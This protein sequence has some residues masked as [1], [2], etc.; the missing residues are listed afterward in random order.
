MSARPVKFTLIELL[1]VIAIIAILAALLLPALKNAKEHGKRAVCVG[2]LRQ[3]FLFSSYFS[4][5]F[6]DYLPPAV[7]GYRGSNLNVTNTLYRL[8]G[9]DGKNF[10]CPAAPT[11]VPAGD[12]INGTT[13]GINIWFI[14]KG[15]PGGPPPGLWGDNDVWFWEHGVF[16]RGQLSKPSS[17]LC[18][19]DSLWSPPGNIYLDNAYWWQVDECTRNQ[20]SGGD[21][22]HSSDRRHANKAAVVFAD[23]HAAALSLAEEIPAF[24]QGMPGVTEGQYRGW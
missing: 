8:D 6:N 4:D 18:Y 12:I 23:G 3:L 15:V 20:G 16:Q 14:S 5:N 21:G 2:N 11:S 10:F 7:W 19:A 13:Y 9:M 1:V 24:T 22:Y 17:T